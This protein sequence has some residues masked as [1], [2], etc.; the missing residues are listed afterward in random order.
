MTAA[1]RSTQRT[2]RPT[3]ATCAPH[4]GHAQTKSEQGRQS[5][6]WPHLRAT[7]RLSSSRLRAARR[8]FGILWALTVSARRNARPRRMR[9]IAASQDHHAGLLGSEAP[10]RAV[11][12][13]APALLSVRHR[14][15]PPKSH[16]PRGRRHAA[17]AATPRR[18]A[19]RGM[20][21]RLQARSSSAPRIPTR[22]AAA[23]SHP[24]A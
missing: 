18:Y 20:S 17:A 6:T 2:A 22:S 4:L 23:T 19:G 3:P 16:Q 12:N 21:G 24:A 11:Q 1:P 10:P 5:R 13:R 8:V 15:P 9:R 7:P 14:R